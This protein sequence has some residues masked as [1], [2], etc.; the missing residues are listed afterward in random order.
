MNYE[1]TPKKMSAR[2]A[3]N[4]GNEQSMLL[5]LAPLFLKNMVMKLVFNAVGEKKSTFTL[6]NLGVVRLP[7][8]MAEHIT[9]M[10]FLLSVQSRAPY[11]TS[12]ITYGDRMYLN[13]IRNIKESVLEREL[14]QTFKELG[15]GVVAE[16]NSRTNRK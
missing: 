9:R 8:E 16:S 1:I 13:I 6:S 4:V 5:K 12:I 15:L 14:Y 7:E 11:N 10:D 3:T 2:I